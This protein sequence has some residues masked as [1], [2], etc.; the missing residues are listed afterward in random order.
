[1]R[2]TV[3][4]TIGTGREER[5]VNGEMIEIELLMRRKIPMWSEGKVKERVTDGT[6]RTHGTETT[7]GM[8]RKT[9]WNRNRNMK[10]VI[11]EIIAGVPDLVPVLDPLH[12]NGTAE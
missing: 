2:E 7:E 11:A 8:G 1:M 5:I 10:I 3:E 6:I 9:G 4:D 12:R